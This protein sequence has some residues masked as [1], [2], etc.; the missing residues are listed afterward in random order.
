MSYILTLKK[1][2][3]WYPM[4]DSWRNWPTG[5]GFP[6]IHWLGNWLHGWTQRVVVD[7]SQLSCS[8]TSGVLQGSV[9]GPTLFSIFINDMDIVIRSGLAKF[10]NDTKLWG[11]ASTPEDRR[12]IQADFDRLR[13]WADK[14]LMV[15]NTEK[16]KVLHLG[17][18][19]LQHPYRLS[20]ATLASTMDE[21]YLGVMI[22]HKMN[23]SLQCDAAASKV[24]K[25]LAC[26]HRCFSSKSRDIILPLYLALVRP[27]LEYCVQFW[28]PQFK[29]D[30]EKLE[31][32]Q[33]RATRMIRGQE[34]RPYDERLR[35]VGLFSLEKRRLRG[36]LVAAHQNLGERLFT[37]VP[38]G[39]TRSKSHKLVQDHFSL[40]DIRKNFFIVRAPKVWNRLPPEVVQ[41]PTLNTFKRN[42]DVYL[43]GIL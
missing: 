14:N 20:S 9:L 41:A 30:V 28:A 5:L 6:M 18:K 29:N 3:T 1:P 39:M 12:A 16:C 22:D 23:M 19:N 38:H 13:K 15:F 31:R 24:S 34:N 25:T 37:R 27:Q 32:V 11:K 17:K 21:K 36:D 7:G 26:I 43:A 2:S 33:K 4:I 42:L 10:T 40:V 8:V 35:A